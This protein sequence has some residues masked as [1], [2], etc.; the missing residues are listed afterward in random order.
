MQFKDIPGHEG[1]KSR[2]REMADTRT[3]PHA[4]IIEG[5][6]GTGKLALAEA[7]ATYIH[8]TDRTPD[9]DSCGRC[10]SCRQHA[11]MSHVDMICSF[12]V[13]KRDTN[14]LSDDFLAE[15]RKFRSE[16]MFADSERWGALLNNAKSNVKPIIYVSESA[17]L[18]RRL[19]VTAKQSD[20]RV[21][22]QWLP[23]RMNEQAANRL[24][25]LIEEP[26]PDTIFIFVSDE[27]T[28]ILP[29]VYSRLQRLTASRLS[30]AEVA[31]WLQRRGG[32]DPAGAMALA[33]L[34]EGNMIVA[35]QLLGENSSRRDHFERFKALMRLAYQRDVTRL[36]EWSTALAGEGRE[37]TMKFYAMAMRLVRENFMFNFSNPELVYLDSEE[38]AFSRNFARFISEKNVEGLMATFQQA[39]DDIAGNANGKIVNFD[40]AIQTI[41][42]IKNA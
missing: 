11:A 36:R 15:W 26:F 16:S 17:A 24:L 2:L 3:V 22:V 12:P 32:L 37:K 40:V 4:M 20:Y 19:A 33:H 27:P 34:A 9:G 21:V 14:P 29:T 42:H 30:D 28:R 13:V 23:E 1:L 10:P 5:P 38:S 18:I 31:S 7:M 41:F 8:C 35:R 6:P 25:K 39:H